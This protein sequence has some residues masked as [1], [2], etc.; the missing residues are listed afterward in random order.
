MKLNQFLAAIFVLLLLLSGF[1]RLAIA[2]EPKPNIVL[3]LCDDL[4]IGDVHCFNPDHGLI[5][6]PAIDALAKRGMMFTDAH[7]GSSVCTP[8]RYGLLTG[9]HSWRT[10]LQKGVVT[11]FAPCLIAADRPTIGSFLQEQGYRT[12]IVGKWH[13]NMKFMDPAD[14]TVELKAGPYKSTPP[15]GSTTPDGPINR[16]FDYFYGIH[17]ARSM[18]AVIEQDTVLEHQP[19]I[20]FLPT[21][22]IKAIEFIKQQ[23]DSKQPFFLYVPLGSPHTPIL[24]TK[25][26][27]GKSGLNPYADFVMQTDHVIGNILKCLDD[28]KLTD[29]TLV[30]FSSDNGCSRQAKIG[31]LR[32]LGHDVSAGYRGSKADIW[33]GGH[34]VPFIASWPNHIEPDSKCDQMIGLFDM[35]AT[36]GDCIGTKVPADSCEDSVSFFPAFKGEPIETNREGLIHH[37]ISGHFAYRTKQWKLVLARGSGGWSSPTEKQVSKD[38][39]EGQLYRMDSDAA[40]QTN[41]YLSEPEMVAQLLEKLTRDVTNGRTTEGNPSSNDVKK[42]KLWKSK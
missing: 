11:G 33:D 8:T 32:K 38:A 5:K 30:I 15:T 22:E 20:S 4:G 16:G 26:W 2:G 13:L 21:S 18:K 10:T 7:S 42:I 17:H 28:Q 27:Q 36:I 41:L 25:E 35:F 23:A 31:Q 3:I 19:P 39:P 29:N 40:E 1:S 12:G 37:S 24:P 34:R 9:R 14:K 6:T